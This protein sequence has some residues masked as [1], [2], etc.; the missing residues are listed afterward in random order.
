[1]KRIVSLLL[2]A[3]MCCLLLA[4]CADDAIGADLEGYEQYRKTDT[5]HPMVLD[6]YIVSET[7]D[8]SAIETVTR[9]INAYLSLHYNTTLDL[10]FVSPDNYAATLAADVEKPGADRADIVLLTSEDMFTSFYNA[11]KLVN[12]ERYYQGKTFGRL[13]SPEVI[14][15]AL[16]NASVAPDGSRYVVPNNRVVGE[17]GYYLV[18]KEIAKHFYYSELDFKAMKYD[19]PAMDAALAELSSGIM[20]VYYALVEVDAA[21][22][23]CYATK[24]VSLPDFSMPRSFAAADLDKDFSAEEA[25]AILD[26]LFNTEYKNLITAIDAEIAAAR[27]EITAKNTEIAALNQQD[28]IPEDQIAA[29]SAEI[30]ALETEI[31]GRQAIKS[32]FAEAEAAYDA[33]LALGDAG[34]VAYAGSVAYAEY[35]E[36]LAAH[37]RF[38]DFKNEYESLVANTDLSAVDSDPAYIEDIGGGDYFDR[39]EYLDKYIC[40]SGS[41]FVTTAEAHASSYAIIAQDGTEEAN[42]VHYERCMEIIYALNTEADFKN[43]M[44]YGVPNTHYLQVDTYVDALTGKVLELDADRKFIDGEGRACIVDTDGKIY[45]LNAEGVIP[46]GAESIGKAI[47]V[48]SVSHEGLPRTYLMN[49]EYTGSVF[50]AHYNTYGEGDV[51]HWTAELAVSGKIQNKEALVF[52]GE[53]ADPYYC[54]Y[55]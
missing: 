7:T 39:L 25:L 4:G 21:V 46:A 38:H 48:T 40:I 10:H 49:M 42:L 27:D 34:A 19:M 18:N 32:K 36:E 45:V 51:N 37:Y 35:L 47:V 11:G 43:L 24:P 22:G 8:P 29:L 31:A 26:N 33:F 3:L 12:L 13:N 5:R 23:A 20:Q 30:A 15:E 9:E 53:C 16:L 52:R 50:N 44:Q 2:C 41:P 1:M 14:A 17:Y 28:P 55:E 54:I 6:F